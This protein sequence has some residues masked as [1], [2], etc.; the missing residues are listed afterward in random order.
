MKNI[1]VSVT[2]KSQNLEARTSMKFTLLSQSFQRKRT[3]T[4]SDEKC[5]EVVVFL[6]PHLKKQKLHSRHA[7]QEKRLICTKI[8]SEVKKNFGNAFEAT[9]HSTLAITISESLRR[10][11]AH[12]L[13]PK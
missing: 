10:S 3:K 8:N 1:V 5:L 4:E 13:I 9:K 11:L 12:S 2:H 6:H 7:Q